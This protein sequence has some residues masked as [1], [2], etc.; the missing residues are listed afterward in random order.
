MSPNSRWLVVTLKGDGGCGSWA[1]AS[2]E[3]VEG[4]S[5]EAHIR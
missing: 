1:H 4:R 3:W 2:V 5:Q